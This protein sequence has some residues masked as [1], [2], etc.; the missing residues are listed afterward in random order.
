MFLHLVYYSLG[1][2]W[3]RHTLLGVQVISKLLKTL[4]TFWFTSLGMRHLYH[5]HWDISNDIKHVSNCMIIIHI[6]PDKFLGEFQVI[7][8]EGKGEW[9]VKDMQSFPSFTPWVS[10][11]EKG[12]G[13]TCISNGVQEGVQMLIS[14]KVLCLLREWS[15]L[16]QTA[17]HFLICKVL[18][19]IQSYTLIHIS[20]SSKV[21]STI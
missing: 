2:D 4:F 18:Q 21:G 5:S 11:H 15:F 19:L 1:V 17:R 10:Q 20:C 8:R 7:E 16:N 3:E 6:K 13:E 9:G 14:R 12:G